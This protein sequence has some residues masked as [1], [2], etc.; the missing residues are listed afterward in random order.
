MQEIILPDE[1]KP[2]LEWV[3]N[4]VLPKVSPQR[5]HSLAQ[6]RFCS[7]LDAWAAQ[8][9]FGTVGPEWRFLVQPPGE[10]GRTLVPDVAYLSFERMPFEEQADSALPRVAPDAVVEVKSPEDA[11]KDIDEKTRV[12]LA[13]G[14]G[15][16]FVVDP[17]KRSVT[18][19]DRS[20]DR[21]VCD[22]DDVTHASLPGF[23]MPACVLF[24]PIRPR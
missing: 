22:T 4:R 20:G 24:D 15:V 12:Y 10:I 11:R 19:R 21:V 7:A 17:W 23:R 3:N 13:G 9:R 18:V 16:V 14:T 5:K 8:G 1:P 6:G 2:A